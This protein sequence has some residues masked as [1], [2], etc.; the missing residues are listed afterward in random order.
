MTAQERK[1]R[2]NELRRVYAGVQEAAK[3]RTPTAGSRELNFWD[4]DYYLY[5]RECEL[6]NK[7]PLPT[8]EVYVE[9]Q[10]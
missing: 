7:K 3:K 9:N 8:Y 5:L 2:L 10:R 4:L 6:K 1:L